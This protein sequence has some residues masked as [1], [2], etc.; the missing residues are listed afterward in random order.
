[1]NL[2]KLSLINLLFWG[3][4]MACAISGFYYGFGLEVKNWPAIIGFMV[5]SRW[6]IYVTRGC[7]Q[8]TRKKMES[9]CCKRA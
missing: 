9:V 5:L 6:V 8:L 4:D 1:M 2:L 3:V 7:Y